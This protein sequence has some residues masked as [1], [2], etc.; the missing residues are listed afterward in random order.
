VIDCVTPLPAFARMSQLPDN[1]IIEFQSKL[2]GKRISSSST[3]NSEVVVPS[4]NA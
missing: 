2:I 1:L 3:D 4:G